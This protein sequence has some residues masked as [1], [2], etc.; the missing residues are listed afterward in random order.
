[1][2]KARFHEEKH[3]NDDDSHLFNYR[4]IGCGAEFGDAN[5][6]SIE[7]CAGKDE[8]DSIPKEDWTGLELLCCDENVISVVIDALSLVEGAREQLSWD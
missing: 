4:A 1:V 6:T 3:P 2:T 8:A 5:A 7:D